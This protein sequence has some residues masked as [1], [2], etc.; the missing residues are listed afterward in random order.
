[1][2]AGI[3]HNGSGIGN[4]LARYVAVRCLALDK[5]Y[6]FAMQNP[7]NNKVAS[8]MNLEMKTPEPLYKYW[9]E[10][11]RKLADGTDIRGYD[12]TIKNV[13]DGTLLDGEMQDERYF[14]HHI[15]EIREWLAV[16]PLE[17]PDD[18][19]VINFRGGEYNGLDYLF[20]KKKYWDDAINHMKAINPSMRFEVH[21]DDP[22]LAKTFFPEGTVI[23]SGA[24][25]NW[26]TIRYAKYLIL[27]N[28]SFAIL[29]AYLN[30]DVKK[31]IAPKYWARHNVSNGYWA[32]SQNIHTPFTYMDREGVLFTAD[33]CRQE[34]SPIP[35]SMGH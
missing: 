6:E 2:I 33:Q 26:R 21:T 28:S 4:Q 25:I 3:F 10:Q 15:D 29:P 27:S 32:L 23:V 22:L 24:A 1:M 30:Q 7:Q 35:H 19:C 34:L 14:I 9:H 31:I 18:L 12:E 5:G 8:F 17:L 20:L 16:E 13:D 11:S